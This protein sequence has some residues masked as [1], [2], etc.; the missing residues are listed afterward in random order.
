MLLDKLQIKHR[1]IKP[2]NILLLDHWI[3]ICDF[4]ISRINLENRF[5]TGVGTRIY[6]TPEIR[7]N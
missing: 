6:I 4:D 7:A 2:H 5:T 3:K 1:D